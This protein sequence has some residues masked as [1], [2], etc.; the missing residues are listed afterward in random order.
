MKII[1]NKVFHVVLILFLTMFI[2][3]LLIFNNN[4]SGL[5]TIGWVLILVYIIYPIISFSLGIYN[6]KNFCKVWF[7]PLIIF[8]IFL[9]S[10]W[11][12]FKKIILELIFIALIY[13]ILSYLG[14]CIPYIIKKVRK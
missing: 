12:I 13:T 11:I 10:Y 3:P 7:I 9:L 2:L 6:G 1:K 5:T 8:V 4:A 14:M